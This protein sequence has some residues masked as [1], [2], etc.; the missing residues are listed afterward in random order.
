MAY[1][2]VIPAE[3]GQ[4]IEEAVRWYEE[5][6]TGL[7]IRFY[8]QVLEMLER[9]VINPK[10]YSFIRDEYRR[11]SVTPFPYNI[12]YKLINTTV[13]VLA[14]FHTSRNPAEIIKRIKE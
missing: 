11:I 7:G 8:Q 1:S 3:A 12:I 4:D 6:Q 2:I 13:I 9:I 5:Q 14:V 10:Y